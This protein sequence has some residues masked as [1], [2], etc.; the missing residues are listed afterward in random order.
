M[1]SLPNPAHPL[2]K[3]EQREL[4]GRY[5]RRLCFFPCLFRYRWGSFPVSNEPRCARNSQEQPDTLSTLQR[6]PDCCLRSPKAYSAFTRQEGRAFTTCC[7]PQSSSVLLIPP[8][9]RASSSL[10]FPISPFCR[11]PDGIIGAKNLRLHALHPPFRWRFHCQA[12]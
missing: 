4:L 6:A 5:F 10:P 12:H 9:H 8:I 3:I 1:A 2:A 7:P 11:T